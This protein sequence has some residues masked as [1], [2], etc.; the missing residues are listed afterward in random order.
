MSDPS[1]DARHAR[2]AAEPPGAPIDWRRLDAVVRPE[3]P[4]PEGWYAVALSED[5]GPD[6]PYGCD[7]ADASS[8]TDAPRPS[9][10]S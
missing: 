2:T 5:V 10:S 7:S 8:S 1:V 3:E 9:R 4:Q 6:R